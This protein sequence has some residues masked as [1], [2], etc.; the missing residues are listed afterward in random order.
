MG[1]WEGRWRVGDEVENNNDFEDFHIINTDRYIIYIR[2][3]ENFV[4]DHNSK[5]ILISYV[6][7]DDILG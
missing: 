5:A 1:G 6:S 7:N 4:V 3:P 2:K